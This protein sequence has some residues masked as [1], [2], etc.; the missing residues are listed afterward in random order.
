M[1]MSADLS[2][3]LIETFALNGPLVTRGVPG[4]V[5]NFVCGVDAIYTYP[6]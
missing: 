6:S 3:P 5:H 4:D 1:I 2:I